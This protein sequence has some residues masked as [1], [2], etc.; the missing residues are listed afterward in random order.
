MSTVQLQQAPLHTLLPSH[1]DIPGP[2]RS[3]LRSYMDHPGSNISIPT[4]SSSSSTTD[5]PFHGLLTQDFHFP[6][7]TFDAAPYR[8]L[9]NPRPP[10]QSKTSALKSE[11]PK[12]DQPQKRKRS[13][14]ETPV[15][16][17]SSRPR[18][19]QHGSS[20]SSHP[21]TSHSSQYAS[22]QGH[23]RSNTLTGHSQYPAPAAVPPPTSAYPIDYAQPQMGML[24]NQGIRDTPLPL[25]R[26]RNAWS[27]GAWSTSPHMSE[28]S[29][30]NSGMMYSGPTG[31]PGDNSTQ[32]SSSWHP[33]HSHSVSNNM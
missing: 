30:P 28:A 22:L 27:E 9:P 16:P 5:D 19:H 3:S 11:R 20:H 13:T 29:N 23:E 4:S 17:S 8:L 18:L 31:Y 12:V 32:L 10:P 33:S 26:S 21:G 15:M 24:P 7:S 2:F 14:D 25:E 1:E 6:A